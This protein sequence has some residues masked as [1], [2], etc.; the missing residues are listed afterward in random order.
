MTYERSVKGASSQVAERAVSLKT[1]T[2]IELLR[3]SLLAYL[4]S[5]PRADNFASWL[6][7]ACAAILAL[8]ISNLDTVAPFISI[9]MV[10]LAGALFM[11]GA[12]NCVTAKAIAV[13][14]EG[15][16]EAIQNVYARV[17]EI[18]SEHAVLAEQIQGE[19][20]NHGLILDTFPDLNAIVVELSTSIGPLSGWFAR[21][22][23]R[24]SKKDPLHGIK[25]LLKISRIQ[26]LL[27]TFEVLS[28]GGFLCVLI[29]GIKAP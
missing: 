5:V 9:E 19:A 11:F 21:R 24:E 20:S 2:H 7:T 23:A 17:T 26:K 28:L 14:L 12:V 16:L 15:Q 27:I 22:G 3:V 25:I 18:M 29:F 4:S 13:W 8:T 1:F 6:L 10:R